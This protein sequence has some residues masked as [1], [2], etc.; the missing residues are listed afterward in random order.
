MNNTRAEWDAYVAR[1]IAALTPALTRLGYALQAA[2]PHVSGERFLF[3]AVT[4]ASGAKLILLGRTADGR[5]VVIKATRDREG[6]RELAH[7]RECRRMLQQIDFAYEL[8]TS[9]EEL[10][11]TEVDGFTIS[12]QAYVE[13]EKAFLDRPLKEQF[14][15]ALGAFK[16]Q[17]GAHATT[18]EHRRM[19]AGAFGS[20]DAIAYLAAFGAFRTEVRAAL[21]ADSDAASVMGTAAAFL[22][23]HREVIE[24]YG[25]F[26]THTDF[27]PHNFRIKDGQIYL[28]DYASLRFGNKYE[29]WARFLNFMALHN[30]PLAEALT[31]YVRLNRTAEEL[32]SLTAM[33]A[34]RLGE[35]ITYYSRNL[36][37]TDGDL[38]ALTK[39]RVAFWTDML[40][41]LLQGRALPAERVT[42]YGALRDSLRSEEEKA[43]QVGL[44]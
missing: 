20:M 4:T 9:P 6:A 35:I 19:I 15:Y 40:E 18:Y 27:V 2:Q 43:R 21:G 41:A 8:F 25:S 36:S 31:E 5:R 39:A 44:N 3:R 1:E 13:Q 37:R 10:L 30:P 26:L 28:L 42:A 17:E 23:E 38:H 16:A 11:F 29:G 24:Q 7:E 33:R 14:A 22:A 12:V 32:E 34:Y